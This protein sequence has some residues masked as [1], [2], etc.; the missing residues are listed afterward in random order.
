[1]RPARQGRASL[2][3]VDVEF[4]GPATLLNW[5]DRLQKGA[6]VPWSRITAD[7]RLREAVAE[8]CRI[9]VNAAYGLGDAKAFAQ[10]HQL[11]GAIYDLDFQSPSL[12]Q[13]DAETQ[14][15]LRDIAA[16]LEDGMF[17]HELSLVDT[18][19]FVDH[20]RRGDDYVDWL[21]RLISSHGASAHPLYG[22]Y[23]A[24][25]ADV[26]D[27]AFFMIQEASLDPRFDDI[28]ALLQIGM[29][30]LHKLE[31]AGNYQD[32]MGN[33]LL[34]DVHT[35]MFSRVLAA[36]GVDTEAIRTHMLTAALAAG[37]LS[38]CMALVRRHRH[39]AIGYFGVTEYLAPRRFKHVV[40]AW[41]R[42]ALPTDGIRYHQAHIGIDAQHAQGW[43]QN[44]I[45]PMVDA[46]PEEGLHIAL[47]VAIRLN[48]SQRTLDAILD[49]FTS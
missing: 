24:H 11:L 38:A 47:G 3:D 45:A 40:A 17:S 35:V 23:I 12:A 14:P 10:V 18:R 22:E 48:S 13:V 5:L 49:H 33:G 8:S 15:V 28:L 31:L 25:R 36:L 1:M 16:I 19:E 44:V 2:T 30:A 46:C 43:M 37:N 21:K 39:K 41:R 34:E 42:N 9:L 32:E 27:L 26:R 29:P 20:P 4:E 7:Y 6:S